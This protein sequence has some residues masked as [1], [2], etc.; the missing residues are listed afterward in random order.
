MKPIQRLTAI[1]AICL[2]TPA[3][4]GDLAVPAPWQAT[5][6]HRDVVVREVIEAPVIVERSERPKWHGS[7][8]LGSP[9]GYTFRRDPIVGVYGPYA[10][11]PD[12]YASY[13]N[14]RGCYRVL[15]VETPRGPALKRVFVCDY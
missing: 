4:A 15:P 2:A 12:P 1:A 7:G 11:A 10:Y 9:W 14:D 13:R 5:R 8:W 3:L 6:G